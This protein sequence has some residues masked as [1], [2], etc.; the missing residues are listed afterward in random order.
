MG[1]VSEFK[2]AAKLVIEHVSFDK[3]CTVQVFEANIR[4]VHS[5]HRSMLHAISFTK[6]YV[7]VV[8]QD[9]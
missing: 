9:Y 8:S 1:N 4:S 7:H 3:D 2:R 6:I 5:H